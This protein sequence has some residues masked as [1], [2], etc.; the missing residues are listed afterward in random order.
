[1]RQKIRERRAEARERREQA[2]RINYE[3]R[4][5]REDSDIPIDTEEPPRLPDPRDTVTVLPFGPAFLA[6]MDDVEPLDGDRDLSESHIM[7]LLDRF[8]QCPITFNPAKAR[9][10]GKCYRINGKHTLFLA[11]LFPEIFE[12]TTWACSTYECDSM[13]EVVMLYRQY[14]GSKR[15]PTAA[16]LPTLVTEGII[17][18]D[19]VATTIVT[20]IEFALY[21]TRN[22]LT[23]NEQSALIKRYH[24]F[25]DWLTQNNLVKRARLPRIT[26][27]TAAFLTWLADAESAKLFWSEVEDGGGP[28][29]DPAREVVDFCTQHESCRS[30]ADPYHHHVNFVIDCWNKWCEN[31]IV[32]RL[33]NG[34]KFSAMLHVNKMENTVKDALAIFKAE[35]SPAYLATKSKKDKKDKEDKE[36]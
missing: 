4:I 25:F 36:E 32:R 21:N 11:Q 10:N 13:S 20:G 33:Y 22:N 9:W 12:G 28:K 16:V 24:S 34:R 2:K 27:Y 30:G 7:N 15:T 17:I 8:L 5:Q 29:K 14:D 31:K 18:Q 35:F 6:F 19:K 23:P 1:M 3:Q 26:N